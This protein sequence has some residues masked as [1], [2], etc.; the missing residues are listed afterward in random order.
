MFILYIFY[1]VT[2]DGPWQVMLKKA[3]GSY[4]CVAESVTRFTLGESAT[5]EE[6]DVELETSSDWRS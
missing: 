3:D 4:S 2:D 1:A 5:W 6:E